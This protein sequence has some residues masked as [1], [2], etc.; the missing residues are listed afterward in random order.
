VDGGDHVLGQV[1]AML[2]LIGS[3]KGTVGAYGASG[4]DGAVPIS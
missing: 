2:A 3:L 1:T 4:S